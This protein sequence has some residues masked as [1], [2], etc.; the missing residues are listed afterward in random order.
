MV[1]HTAQLNIETRRR[2]HAEQR[3]DNGGQAKLDRT[4][5]RGTTHSSAQGRG[6]TPPQPPIRAPQPAPAVR[7]WP[8]DHEGHDVATL[9]S[10]HPAPT[11]T[12]AFPRL[13][14]TL[15]PGPLGPGQR[16][17]TGTGRGQ[18]KGGPGQRGPKQ[19]GAMEQAGGRAK[20]GQGNGQGPGHLP[21]APPRGRV[22]PALHL[23]PPQ[24][25]P[26]RGEACCPRARPTASTAERFLLPLGR[27]GGPP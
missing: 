5:V 18:G 22:T 7:G 8:G 24:P 19:R 2:S 12:P 27:L 9:L 23:R 14:H 20:R 26:P 11:D 4:R 15:S 25:E 1:G 3:P 17:A 16:G 13:P 10:V 21:P 6:P